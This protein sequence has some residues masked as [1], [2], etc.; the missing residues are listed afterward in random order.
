LLTFLVTCVPKIMKIRQCF[1][2]LQLKMSGMFFFETHCIY[3]ILENINT[4]ISSRTSGDRP[5]DPLPP[6]F[7]DVPA[8]LS[9]DV[10]AKVPSRYYRVPR[11]FFMVLTV[12]HNRWYRPT[13]QCAMLKACDAC[14]DM[15]QLPHC[16]DS[17]DFPSTKKTQNAIRPRCWLPVSRSISEKN[18][19]VCNR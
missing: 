3:E 1:L 9:V 15:G 13:L 17:E 4:Y 11:Y 16:T 14:A 7:P 10:I 12:A 6:N 19:K 18:V 8:G 2:E 5:H